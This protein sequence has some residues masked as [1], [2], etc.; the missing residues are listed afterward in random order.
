MAS[1]DR[2]FGMFHPTIGSPQNCF[3]WNFRTGSISNLGRFYPHGVSPN[4]SKVALVGV[5]NV[6][7]VYFQCIYDPK[8]GSFTN[9]VDLQ[10]AARSILSFSCVADNGS[11]VVT[12]LDNYQNRVVRFDSKG[13]LDAQ[14]L[15]PQDGL[16]TINGA[17]PSGG[18]VG[19]VYINRIDVPAYWAPGQLQPIYLKI[20]KPGSFCYASCINDSGAIGGYY[21]PDGPN[22]HTRAVIWPEG[23]R[24]PNNVVDIDAVFGGKMGLPVGE[25][26]S[27]VAGFYP[28]NMMF[29]G[30]T[31]NSIGQQVAVHEFSVQ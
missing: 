22:G 29:Y 15:Q 6:A 7:P 4:G 5:L 25:L 10:S 12:V 2:L 13:N 21:C 19:S 18:L 9:L 31:V 16:I 14:E 17:S 11:G 27:E 23:S 20:P 28:H 1:S 3:T 30:W 8:A 26:L 24:N